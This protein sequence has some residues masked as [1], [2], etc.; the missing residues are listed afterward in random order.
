[1]RFPVK[2]SLIPNLD[3]N[4]TS[5]R[6]NFLGFGEGAAQKVCPTWKLSLHLDFFFFSCRL[7]FIV[8]GKGTTLEYICLKCWSIGLTCSLP[9]LVPTYSTHT[10]ITAHPKSFF[11]PDTMEFYSIVIRWGGWGILIPCVFGWCERIYQGL[12]YT[13]PIWIASSHN[14][15]L[16]LH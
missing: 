7:N 6:L 10:P 8:P 4:F 2:E 3:L 12:L 13:G 16:S 11:L 15:R 14:K 9:F 5:T 1:M